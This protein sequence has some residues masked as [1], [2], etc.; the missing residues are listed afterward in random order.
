MLAEYRKLVG[1]G[2][3]S[4]L[5]GRTSFAGVIKEAVEIAK[6]TQ[7]FQVRTGSLL[8]IHIRTHSNILEHI[9][10]QVLLIITDGC[11]NDN[12]ET[13]QAV[14]EPSALNPKP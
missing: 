14:I 9:L 13:R 12:G 6:R 5:G 7:R 1:L 8:H 11:V 3:A 2:G 4:I 10:T